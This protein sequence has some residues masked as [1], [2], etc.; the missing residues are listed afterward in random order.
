MTV[1]SS[2]TRLEA[3]DW[4]RGIASMWVVLYHVDLTLQKAKYFGLPPLSP[5]TAVGYRG[6]E[7]FFVLSGF[8]MARSYA[9]GAAAGWHDA[10]DFAI[11]RIFRIFPLYLI[12]SIPLFVVAAS[13]G[14]G[15]PPADVA[16]DA[17]LF[18]KNLFLLPR[19]DL[20]TFIPVS[21]WTLSHELMFYAVFLIWFFAPRLFIAALTLWAGLS[22]V[23]TLLDVRPAGWQMQTNALNAYFLAGAACSMLGRLGRPRHLW[24]LGLAAAMLLSAA[25]S[26]EAASR[27]AG[28]AA[29]ACYAAAFCL[30]VY[31]LSFGTPSLP[32]FI[33]APMRYLGRISYGIYLVNYPL[34]VVIALVCIKAGLHAYAVPLV[35][36]GAIGATILVSD[37]LHRFVERPG[38]AL[39]R[40]V[41]RKPLSV[42]RQEVIR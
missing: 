19:D 29:H 25:I 5:V 36:L 21:A 40:R 17:S 12:V 2:S 23:L 26:L 38:I 28:I 8:I 41:F 32:R 7:L 3:L 13:A 1:E 11:R 16:L 22:L 6:V 35:M 30:I 39:G 10:I 18:F 33:E 31:C 15:R 24:V 34:V 27:A 14:I 9:R 20:S 37:L 4:I 42:A